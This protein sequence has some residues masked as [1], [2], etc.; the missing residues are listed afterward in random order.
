MSPAARGD[1]GESALERKEKK[2]GKIRYTPTPLPAKDYP[3]MFLL[4]VKRT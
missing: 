2:D 3:Q 4:P 1:L